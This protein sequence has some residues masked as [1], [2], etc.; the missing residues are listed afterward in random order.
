MCVAIS[1]LCELTVIADK[2]ATV[3]PTMVTKTCSSLISC[4]TSHELSVLHAWECDAMIWN[5]MKRLANQNRV[6]CLF[7]MI[8]QSDMS[9]FYGTEK[10]NYVLGAQRTVRKEEDKTLFSLGRSAERFV[11]S[12]LSDQLAQPEGIVNASY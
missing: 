2:R 5:V 10:N 9:S 4:S 6:N 12:L 1:D 7:D 8:G 11:V 3:Q